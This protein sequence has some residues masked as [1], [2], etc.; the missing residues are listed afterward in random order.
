MYIPFNEFQSKNSYSL[1][2]QVFPQIKLT[3]SRYSRHFST[4]STFFH[5]VFHGF[6]NV[7]SS[8]VS[9]VFHILY[10]FPQCY[11]QFGTKNISN[12][13]KTL[14]VY[15]SESIGKPKD[16]MYPWV[17]VN[18]YRWISLIPDWHLD[19]CLL[20]T[21]YPITHCHKRRS[22]PHYQYIGLEEE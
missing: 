12:G 18:H 16:K 14:N 10:I 9:L 19:T 17:S 6:C 13:F 2:P 7:K 20:G 21:L 15:L 8:T 3:N 5:E 4:L 11:Q 22:L 1:F